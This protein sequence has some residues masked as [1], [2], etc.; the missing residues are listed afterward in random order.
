MECPEC[1][2]SRWK[3]VDKRKNMFECRICGYITGIDMIKR[4]EMKRSH[5]NISNLRNIANKTLADIKDSAKRK[6]LSLKKDNAVRK[7]LLKKAFV[8]ERGIRHFG[9]FRP[10]K[11]FNFTRG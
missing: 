8:L 7:H 5:L 3:T 2:Y 4:K 11:P 9:N 1:G 10:V 6:N